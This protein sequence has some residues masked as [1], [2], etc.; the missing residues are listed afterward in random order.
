MPQRN[1]KMETAKRI[2]HIKK[3]KCNAELEKLARNNEC[4]YIVFF[5]I[6]VLFFITKKCFDSYPIF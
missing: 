3:I 4:M 6:Q 1:R 5:Y 2:E